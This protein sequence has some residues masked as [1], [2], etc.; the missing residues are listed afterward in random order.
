MSRSNARAARQRS[1][2]G[3]ALCALCG[4]KQCMFSASSAKAIARQAAA[5]LLLWCCCAA[6]FAGHLS[7]LIIIHKYNACSCCYCCWWLLLQQQFFWY[8]ISIS[9]V[10]HPLTSPFCLLS[11]TKAVAF[12]FH[13]NCICVCIDVAWSTSLSLPFCLSLSLPLLLTLPLTFI[14]FS[15]F[16]LSLVI[17]VCSFLCWFCSTKRAPHAD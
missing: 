13:D 10:A 4:V 6:Y 7:E 1:H 16:F 2:T 3:S 17:F 8:L 11:T 9:I 12:V 14:N 5:A 15:D